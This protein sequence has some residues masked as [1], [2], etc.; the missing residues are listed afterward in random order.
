MTTI[1]NLVQQNI[2]RLP[3]MSDVTWNDA[4]KTVYV[5]NLKEVSDFFSSTKE[6]VID[7]IIHPFNAPLV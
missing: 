7:E 1:K 5:D 6:F 4:F 2:L 3:A